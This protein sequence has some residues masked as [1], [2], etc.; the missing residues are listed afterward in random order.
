[1]NGCNSNLCVCSGWVG[2]VRLAKKER[3]KGFFPQEVRDAL[4][5]KHQLMHF[6]FNNIQGAS[7]L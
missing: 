5:D 4:N 6:T 7:R 1:V 3:L 2:G